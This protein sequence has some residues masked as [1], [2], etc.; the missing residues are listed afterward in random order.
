M[1]LPHTAV[2]VVRPC[3]RSATVAEATYLL[4]TAVLTVRLYLH[5]KAVAEATYLSGHGYTGDQ[6]VPLRGGH[7]HPHGE[8]QLY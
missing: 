4:D 8:S 7:R 6:I 1:C 2:R 3:V 5:N